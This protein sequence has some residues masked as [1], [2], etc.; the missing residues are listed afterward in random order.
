MARGSMSVVDT[1]L[2]VYRIENLRISGST[3]LFFSIFSATLLAGARKRFPGQ[4]M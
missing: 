1:N 4:S 2:K 3:D